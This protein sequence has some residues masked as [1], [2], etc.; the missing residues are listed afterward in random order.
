MFL[1]RK[2]FKEGKKAG[3]GE[4]MGSMLSKGSVNRTKQQ[5]DE[6]IDFLG[7]QFSTAQNG[8]NV[9]GLSKY[10]DKMLEIAANAVL[11]PAF[12]K[13]NLIRS[14]HKKCLSLLH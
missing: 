6:D 5:L 11:N 14:R 4:F 3:A 9:S 12:P 8:F 10:A 13:M 2:P 1:N 7:A